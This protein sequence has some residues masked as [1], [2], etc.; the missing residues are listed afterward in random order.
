MKRDQVGKIH[1]ITIII[2][3]NILS[4]VNNIYF[5]SVIKCY[6]FNCSLMVKF[7]FQWL[8]QI[9]SYDAT[10]LK[11]MVKL[12]VP[13][14]SIVAGPVIFLWYSL[15][16]IIITYVSKVTHPIVI[17]SS[18]YILLYKFIYTNISQSKHFIVENL[19]TYMY[20]CIFL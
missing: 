7:S 2:I 3:V 9:I 14:W 19:N 6:Q 17:C 11:T 20:T 15:V 8:Q 5:L 13:T 12:Y 18:G 16:A 4:S 1:H 10:N